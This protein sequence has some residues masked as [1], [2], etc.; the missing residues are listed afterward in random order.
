MMRGRRPQ[1]EQMPGAPRGAPCAQ[2]GP[3]HGVGVEE[4]DKEE[5]QTEH[6]RGLLDPGL[7]G[8]RVTVQHRWPPPV[9]W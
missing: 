2:V 9:W 7:C 4:E 3:Q 6:T 8:C 1:A 5:R